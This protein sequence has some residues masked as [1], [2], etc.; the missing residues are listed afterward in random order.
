LTLCKYVLFLLPFFAFAIAAQSFPNVYY[1]GYWTVDP[2]IRLYNIC[3][4]GSVQLPNNDIRLYTPGYYGIV[5]Y[6]SSDGLNFAMDSGIRIN[7][8][9][10]YPVSEPAVIPLRNGSYRIYYIVS[11]SLDKN[12]VTQ[13]IYTAVSKDGFK[14]YGMR[15]ITDPTNQSFNN[16][17][18]FVSTPSV[19]EF[20]NGMVGIYYVYTASAQPSTQCKSLFRFAISSDGINFTDKG[21]VSFASGKSYNFIDPAWVPLPN[22]SIMLISATQSPL[23][24]PAD[25]ALGLYVSYSTDRTWLNF[26]TPKL[27]IAPPAG[28]TT[29]TIDLLQDP[30]VIY[31]ANG[32]YRMYYDVYPT[33]RNS[34]YAS[35]SGPIYI[36][37]ASWLP[38][39]NVFQ[40]TTSMTTA[41]STFSTVSST[42]STTILTTSI[43]ITTVNQTPQ[44]N[45]NTNLVLI[46]VA[47]ITV[48]ALALTFYYL[49]KRVG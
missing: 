31:L 10:N 4:P 27:I 6:I 30:D 24:N 17:T 13:Q 22:G 12:E 43:A 40:N 45:S 36:E 33:L 46:V 38:T 42:I 32:T 8:S 3:C 15:Q 47:I 14:F 18:G 23:Y 35:P 39:P 20:A 16:A 37:S 34:N 1:S 41:T 29:Y 5:S 48:V 9:T 25:L 26:T 21:C 2:G 44:T 11:N 28:N 19:R 49:S 7:N